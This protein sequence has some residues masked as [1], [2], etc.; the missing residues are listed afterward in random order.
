MQIISLNH[1][2]TLY[3]SSL[4]SPICIGKNLATWLA[5]VECQDPSFWPC[6]L[7]VCSFGEPGRPKMLPLAHQP[8]MRLACDLTGPLE[9]PHFVLFTQSCARTCT[10]WCTLLHGCRMS[11]PLSAQFCLRC[12]G[13]E[14]ATE[15]GVDLPNQ[16]HLSQT[17]PSTNIAHNASFNLLFCCLSSCTMATVV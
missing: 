8:F 16:S 9:P 2:W 7:L 1:A 12:A 17:T 5:E 6:G 15:E 3:L 11:C 10:L 13:N 4:S 14:Q